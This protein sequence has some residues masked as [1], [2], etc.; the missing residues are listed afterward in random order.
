LREPNLDAVCVQEREPPA[1]H[2][3]PFVVA[4][5]HRVSETG[6]EPG[7]TR[8]VRLCNVVSVSSCGYNVVV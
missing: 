3:V 8:E 1:I 6:H 5:I 4:L 2:L 7:L